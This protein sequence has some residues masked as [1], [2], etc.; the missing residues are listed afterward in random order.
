MLGTATI[1]SVR[2]TIKAVDAFANSDIVAGHVGSAALGDITTANGGTAFGIATKK[3]GSFAGVFASSAVHV[4][5]SLLQNEEVLQ[6]YLQSQG[7]QLGDFSIAL[8][9]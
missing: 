9:T 6:A 1:G 4:S 7:D 8:L 5:H 3:L 2:V